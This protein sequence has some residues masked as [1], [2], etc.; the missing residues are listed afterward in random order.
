MRACAILVVAAA[1]VLTGSTAISSTD[2]L[3][4]ATLSKTAQDV[5]LSSV[6]AQP[7][8][9]IQ[10]RLEKHKTVNTNS[11]MEYESEAEAIGL[12]P[13]KLTNLVNK[14]KKGV[15]EVLLKTKSL[16]QLKKL[17][18][19]MEEKSLFALTDLQKKGYTPETLRD[20]IKNTPPKG[21]KNADADELIK[22]YDEYWKIFH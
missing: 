2:A 8:S 5:E 19:K 11:E 7:R 12:L 10:R 6:A 17:S 4:L 3:E 16:N 18:E 15:G 13:E 1:A 20:A 21:M 14:F 9:N 22:F